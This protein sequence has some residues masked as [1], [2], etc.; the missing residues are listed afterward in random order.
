MSEHTDWLPF[1][2]GFRVQQMQLLDGYVQ[3]ALQPAD[4]SVLPCGICGKPCTQMHEH[5]SRRIRDLPILRTQLC[6]ACVQRVAP[7]NSRSVIPPQNHGNQ[8]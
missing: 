8:R 5:F 7:L 6:T 4:C 1:W 2:Q 3:V